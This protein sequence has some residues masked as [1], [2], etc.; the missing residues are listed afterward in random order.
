MFDSDWG[1]IEISQYLNLVNETFIVSKTNEKGIITYV[2]DKFVKISGYSKD[3]L[4]GKPHNI[5]R[6]PQ[7]PSSVFENLWNTIKDGK[8]FEGVL[9]NKAKDGSSYV[10]EVNI[11]PIINEN[12]ANEYLSIR[13]DI[14]KYALKKEAEVLNASEQIKIIINKDGFIVDFSQKAGEFLP[15]LKV[16]DTLHSALR[17]DSN[18][19]NYSE[20][21]KFITQLD[22]IL[23][24]MLFEKKQFQG[25][26]LQ[27]K[28]KI[29]SLHIE[30]LSND[31]ILSFIDI[32]EKE[33]EK[34]EHQR[35]LDESKDKM[36]MVFTHELKTPLN[37]IIG[38]SE[39]LSKRLRR[40]LERGVKDKDIN[41]YLDLTDD[42]NALG[43]NLFSMIISLLDSAKLKS[44]E[45]NLSKKEFL[46][47]ELIKE[48]ISLINKIYTQDVLM[49]IDDFNIYSDQKSIEHI[50]TN[51]FT[52]ALKYGDGKVYISLKQN[53]QKFILT[54]EDN[55]KGINEADKERIF[56]MFEQLDNS[57]VT[58]ETEG[59]G[60]GMH[61]VKQLCDLL[62]FS[63]EIKKS[64][65][66]GGAS[67]VISGDCSIEE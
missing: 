28:D 59:T 25:E 27:Y 55:G 35:K 61:F 44:N 32:T 13:T 30:K 54:V 14:T 62:K 22:N 52:N 64:D 18:K 56:N 24:D 16:N 33:M 57:E 29:F 38:F 21:R 1:I 7:V 10:T 17:I 48:K 51:L 9:K 23:I 26:T 42:I 37:G 15:K 20:L 46:F 3:E 36:L 45:Y 12:G 63:I 43:H 58:R 4:I 2:N 8:K 6:H 41:R 40:G 5:V 47:S 34:Q 53:G 49:E 65:R 50:F 39:V 11:F 19:T 66:L 67:F 31:F 60:I